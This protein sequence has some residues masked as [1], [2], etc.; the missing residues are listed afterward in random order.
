MF[1]FRAEQI[2]AHIK[3]IQVQR[4]RNVLWSKKEI[5]Q[6]EQN[7]N[8]IHADHTVSRLPRVIWP[9]FV[10]NFFFSTNF[11]TFLL[12]SKEQMTFFSVQSLENCIFVTISMSLSIFLIII[13]FH[14]RCLGYPK[15]IHSTHLCMASHVVIHSQSIKNG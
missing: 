14:I 8:T 15:C 5:R 7:L 3:N 12:Q 11:Y 13:T 1:A 6:S 2:S 4:A 9:V 10:F